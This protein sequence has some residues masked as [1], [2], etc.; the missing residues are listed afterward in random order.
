MY[1]NNTNLNVSL[2]GIRSSSMKMWQ[3]N[4]F[5]WTGLFVYFR[6]LWIW[7]NILS[8]T[9]QECHSICSDPFLSVWVIWPMCSKNFLSWSGLTGLSVLISTDQRIF[10]IVQIC[11]CK[12]SLFGA[13]PPPPY[14][15]S[16]LASR[17]ITH[18]N[19]TFGAPLL[20]SR[21]WLES[22]KYNTSSSGALRK[23]V[24]SPLDLV[25][26]CEVSGMEPILKSRQDT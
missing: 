11:R 17:S 2:W 21:E 26:Q 12:L 14:V 1:L 10:R 23:T 5:G 13:Q 7:L 19:S 16:I 9:A 6:V 8:E 20:V 15:K 18:L 3:N 4:W 25:D 22:Q 24:C